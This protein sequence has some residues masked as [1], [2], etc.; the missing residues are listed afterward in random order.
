MSGVTCP[1]SPVTCHMSCVTWIFFFIIFFWQNGDAYWW[2][3]CYQWGLPRLILMEAILFCSFSLW[4]S[5]CCILWQINGFQQQM[6]SSVGRT[7]HQMKA[8]QQ[9]FL[10]ALNSCNT[11]VTNFCEIFTPISY[12]FVFENF[13]WHIIYLIYSI[14]QVSYKNNIQK[15]NHVSHVNTPNDK[16]WHNHLLLLFFF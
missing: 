10:L 16:Y 1:M 4:M 2:R 5:H 8:S 6:F 9:S 14:L 15:R 13:F 12:F 7:D 11:G 3:V